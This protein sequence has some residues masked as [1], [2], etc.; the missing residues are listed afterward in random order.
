MFGKKAEPPKPKEPEVSNRCAVPFV[1][2]IKAGENEAASAAAQLTA[3]IAKWDKD[4][5]A[6]SHLESVTTLR[7][8][9][10]LG[11]LAGNAQSVVSFQLA[12][13]ERKQAEVPGREA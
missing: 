10:C 13:L 1:P 4:G 6:F 11:G 9:G 2:V 5:W 8:N 12:I 3:M 7:N